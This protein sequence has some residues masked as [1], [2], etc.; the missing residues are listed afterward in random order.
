MGSA[1][2][3]PDAFAATFAQ[4]FA[5]AVNA[6]RAALEGIDPATVGSGVSGLLE[7]GALHRLHEIYALRI[8][9]ELEAASLLWRSAEAIAALHDASE[10]L[11]P[12]PGGRRAA[13]LPAD[14]VAGRAPR[15]LI[16][17]ESVHRRRLWERLR[18]A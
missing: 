6:A 11:A 12:A 8:E 1:S 7:P 4:R 5:D 10:A 9:L 3:S 15:V 18:A 2:G 14:E 17:E 16:Q 13:G